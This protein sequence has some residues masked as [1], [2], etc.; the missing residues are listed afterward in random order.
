MDLDLHWFS[1]GGIGDARLN[2]PLVLGH[3]F[4]G[5]TENGIRV[6]VDPAIP[7]RECEQCIG[8]NP[9]LCEKVIFAGHGDKDGA[10]R[11]WVTWDER[12]LFP[13]PDAVTYSDAAMLEPL[14]V[15]IHS[16]DL[17]HLQV[18]MRVGVFGC[19]PIGFLII[20]LARLAGANAITA[21]DKLAHRLDAAEAFGAN[22]TFFAHDRSE[23]ERIAHGSKPRV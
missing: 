10:L 2:H 6:A 11:E 16:V 21:S 15:A 19:G 23:V 5:I 8:G 1:E 4:S 3:E 14:G 9:N 22:H 7:C 20:Q 13:I 17:A 18:G 12:N